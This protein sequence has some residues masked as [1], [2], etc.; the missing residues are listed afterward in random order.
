MNEKMSNENL[1]KYYNRWGLGGVNYVGSRL[2]GNDK[3]ES[4]IPPPPDAYGRGTPP[5]QGESFMK[6]KLTLA[7]S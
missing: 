5:S 1:K 3:V 6:L 4:I 7:L 2:G